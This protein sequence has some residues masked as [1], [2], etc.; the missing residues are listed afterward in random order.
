M[1]DKSVPPT[2]F[3]PIIEGKNIQ[4][5]RD[6]MEPPFSLRATHKTIQTLS[7]FPSS[8]RSQPTKL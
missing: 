6:S 7:K 5:M 2:L 8:I 4:R 1:G 3:F